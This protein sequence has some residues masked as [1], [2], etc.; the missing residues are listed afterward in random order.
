MIKQNDFQE[1]S[2]LNNSNGTLNDWHKYIIPPDQIS[3]DYSYL[4]KKYNLRY[5]LEVN[6]EVVLSGFKGKNIPELYTPVRF[7]DL[8]SNQIIMRHLGRARDEQERH[9][10]E[11]FKQSIQ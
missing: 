6:L 10:F 4:R 2:R 11:D 3:R 1:L 9:S 8:E 5:I 7:I